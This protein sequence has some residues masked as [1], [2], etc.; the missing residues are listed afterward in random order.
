MEIIFREMSLSEN[1]K[2]TPP[3]KGANRPTNLV[4]SGD[5]RLAGAVGRGRAKI[6]QSTLRRGKNIRKTH[7]AG[8]KGKKRRAEAK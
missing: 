3:S 1:E 5:N 7:G 6:K 8:G 2:I 4:P